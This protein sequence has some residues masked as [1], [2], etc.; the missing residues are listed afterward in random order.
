MIKTLAMK[1][2]S[3]N[4]QLDHRKKSQIFQNQMLK[5]QPLPILI[6][7]KRHVNPTICNIKTIKKLDFN[8]T[9]FKR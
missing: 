5:R 1:E 7:S 6:Q 2:I 4:N 3:L 9:E 8:F